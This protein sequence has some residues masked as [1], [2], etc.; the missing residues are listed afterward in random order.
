M[1]STTRVVRRL[2][3]LTTVLLVVTFLVALLLN[4]LPGDPAQVIAGDNATAEQ[5]AQVR[6]DLHLDQSIWVQY[7]H[8][9]G[10]VLSGDL[11]TS[12]RTGQTVLDAV[13]QRLP[14]SLQL[15]LMAQA[16]AILVAIPL[17]LLMAHRPRG[18]LARFGNLG[19]V[20]AISTPEF[21][22]ALGLIFLG[23][24]T[25]GW[26]PAT[27]FVPMSDGIG[28]NIW[29]MMLPALAV[30]IEPA[31]TYLRLLRGDLERTLQ[32]DFI[33][34]AH[35]K[36]MSTTNILFRQA[37]RPSSISLTTLAGL[38]IARLLGTAVVVE[39]IFGLPGMGRL[40]VESIN[41]SDLVMVQGVVCVIALAYVLVNALTD[42]AYPLIDPRM[43]LGGG[44]A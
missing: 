25:F 22:L 37:L 10:G 16:I 19:S 12:Y 36:G 1:S 8:W 28:A 42:L 15:M 14:V 39:S 2:A 32:D 26:F 38:N 17:A 5:V 41:A 9:M 7:G 20:I 3:H 24:M 34:A 11:G 31:G 21:V 18:L 35:A 13:L 29:S 4:M 23:A 30:A 33:L 27:G 6:A 43:R 40:M 44:R